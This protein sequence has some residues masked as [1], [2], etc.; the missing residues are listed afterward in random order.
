MASRPTPPACSGSQALSTTSIRR[1][2]PC[3]CS[4]EGDVVTRGEFR[5]E[6]VEGILQSYQQL[7]VAQRARSATG[8]LSSNKLNPALF[9]QR[10]PIQYSALGAGI[11]RSTIDIDQVADVC[12]LVD[13][14]LTH[15]GKDHG[16]PLWHALATLS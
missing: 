16:Q 2:S 5:P 14:A 3:I 7:P 13:D 1:R 10:P 12:P 9:P 4:R 15:G 6:Y 8:P 11:E